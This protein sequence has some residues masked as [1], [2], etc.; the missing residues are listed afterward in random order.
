MKGAGG[1]Q[2]AE[3]G[4]FCCAGALAETAAG[5]ISLRSCSWLTL[6]S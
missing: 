6:L 5:L 3:G 4:L 1:R 2:G